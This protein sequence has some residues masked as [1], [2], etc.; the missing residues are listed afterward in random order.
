MIAVTC[1]SCGAVILAADPAA[2]LEECL[3]REVPG[4]DPKLA[5]LLFKALMPKREDRETWR[6]TH[7]PRPL[8]L[9]AS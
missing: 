7:R 3:S 6:P 8:P 1:L 9:S 2:A 5:A 4:L